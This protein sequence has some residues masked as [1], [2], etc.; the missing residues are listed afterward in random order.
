MRPVKVFTHEKRELKDAA[1]PFGKTYY[2]KVEKGTGLFHCWGNNFSEFET[3]PG[4]FTV[5]VVEMPD[6]TVLTPPAEDI[7][8]LVAN[9]RS[10]THPTEPD[11][12]L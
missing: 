5:A 10:Q 9:I 3:G 1:H 8:F 12:T 7:Q 11:E 2:E 4:N 6:G